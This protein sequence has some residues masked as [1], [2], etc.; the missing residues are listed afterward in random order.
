MSVKVAEH[1][2]LPAVAGTPMLWCW[3]TAL[4]YPARSAC[5]PRHRRSLSLPTTDLSADGRDDDY[6]R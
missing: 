3:L 1:D 2:L 5:R 6:P 4:L